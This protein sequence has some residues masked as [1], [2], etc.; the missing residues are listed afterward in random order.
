M[1][2]ERS[3]KFKWVTQGNTYEAD[4]RVLSFG[5]CDVI[6]GHDWMWIYD[7]V[8]FHLKKNALDVTKRG[9]EI[10]IA[11]EGGDASLKLM[12]GGSFKK[13]INKTTPAFM[14]QSFHIEAQEDIPVIPAPLNIVLRRFDDVFQEPSGLLPIRQIE[15][16]I[17]LKE[18][19]K[20][21]CQKP[22]RY[23]HVLKDGIEKLVKEML[24]QG[25]ITESSS[26]FASP[27]LLV[28]KKDSTWRMC[29]DYRKLNEI[30][31]K[32]KFPMPIIDVLL[33]ELHG[34]TLFS[35]LDLR[36]GYFQIRLKEEDRVKSAFITHHGSYEF[37][38]MPF[39]LT[40]A[41][42]TF[43]KMMD[44]I[45]SELLRKHVLVFFD[46]ILIYGPDMETHCAHLQHV[47]IVLR[48]HQLYA[49]KSKC[50]FGL[51]HI[52]YLGYIISADGAATDASKVK[53]MV[54]WPQPANLKALRAFLDLTG[55]YMRFVAGYGIIARPLTELTKKGKFKWS[56]QAQ[57]T[58][59][60]LKS[61]L[62]EAPVLALP[63]FQEPF[64][65]ETDVCQSI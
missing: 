5:G 21:A 37:K 56:E 60:Q 19:A 50:G 51:D 65:I 20:P 17:E 35:K 49:K 33:S 9:N 42:S 25:L 57:T 23:S 15:L 29:I 40:N 6:I 26:S 8:T 28:K 58:F 13:L 18:D 38:I 2:R 10:Q 3:S 53:A 7:P 31:V 30:I 55:Y 61:K 27:V 46:D 43:Q 39:G 24:A 32:D 52:E 45:F 1:S 4:L 62:S 16:K 41:P 36:Q 59:E 44:T 47:L 11:A 54:E 48:K 64:I 14:A 22:C 12:N 34:A 63:Y